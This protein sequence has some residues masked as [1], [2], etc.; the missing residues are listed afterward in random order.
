MNAVGHATAT[1]GP[2][3]APARPHAGGDC[4]TAEVAPEAGLPRF[5][6]GAQARLS[7]PAA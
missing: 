1:R 5:L 3:T 4:C 2:E 6:G 7:L